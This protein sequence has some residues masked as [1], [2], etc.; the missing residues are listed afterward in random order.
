MLLFR[1]LVGI[2]SFLAVSTLIIIIVILSKFGGNND[3]NGDGNNDE[4]WWEMWE[5][6]EAEERGQLMFAG[7]WM[8]LVLSFLSVAGFKTFRAPTMF[9]VGVLAGSMVMYANLALVVCFFFMNLEGQEE[10]GNNNNN[11]DRRYMEENNNY[12]NNQQREEEEEGRGQRILSIFG[13]VLFIAYGALSAFTL[14]ISKSFAQDH[15]VNELE[16]SQSSGHVDVLADAF[17]HLSVFSV[18]GIAITFIIG[19]LSL[20]TEDA[21][22]M[23]EEGFVYN[24]LLVSAFVL[25]IVVGLAVAGYRIFRRNP[26]ITQL[27]V[28]FFNG[29]LYFFCGVT[30]LLAGLYGGF[31]LEGVS[32]VVYDIYVCVY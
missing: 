12:N 9:R 17:K 4:S 5:G 25:L 1:S 23:R 8:L 29:C 15:G 28:G 13:L 11:Q 31:S 10:G 22:R 26:S 2:S 16:K 19:F 30:L 20:F 32:H 18:I 6:R 7:V 21:E 27:E 14:W 24:F 3:E